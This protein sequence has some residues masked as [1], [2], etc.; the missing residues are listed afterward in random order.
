MSIEYQKAMEVVKKLKEKE[1]NQAQKIMTLEE[2][3][4]AIKISHQN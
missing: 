1:M 3:H 2:S 4:K